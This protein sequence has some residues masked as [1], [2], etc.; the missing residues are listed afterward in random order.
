[1]CLFVRAFV[2]VAFSLFIVL[3]LQQWWPPSSPTLFEFRAVRPRSSPRKCSQTNVLIVLFPADSLT[4]DWRGDE[5]NEKGKKSKR[6]KKGKE[7]KKRKR[8]NGKWT[9]TR[10]KLTKR[11]HRWTGHYRYVHA[12]VFGPLSNQ[13]CL[14]WQWFCFCNLGRVFVS[15]NFS[16]VS[17]KRKRFVSKDFTVVF[18]FSDSEN[19]F[20]NQCFR[21]SRSSCLKCFRG[22][23]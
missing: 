12:K 19:I 4:R 17:S 16:I 14:L 13:L 9:K 22:F 21:I 7:R 6:K 23:W 15:R 2:F 20:K 11:K 10:R 5:R 8:Q 18:F 3:K 1:M